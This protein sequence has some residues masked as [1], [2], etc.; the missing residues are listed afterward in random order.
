MISALPPSVESLRTPFKVVIAGYFNNIYAC[1]TA[2]RCHERG[3]AVTAFLF[4]GT[5][6]REL[7]ERVRQERTPGIVSPRLIDIVDCRIPSF[8]VKS[9]ND[10]AAISL[11]HD[12]S[13]DIVLQGMGPILKADFLAVPRIGILNSH[14]GL[15]PRYQGCSAVEWSIY[16]DDPVGST[17]H[18]L[19]EDVDAGPI[20]CSSTFDIYRG[21]TYQD[22]RT[23][24]FYHE[25][26]TLISGLESVIQGVR[27]AN[28]TPQVDGVYHPSAPHEILHAVR[29]KLRL[30]TY[31][32]LKDRPS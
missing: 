22:V 21:D 10:P 28:A 20:I 7:N 3:I 2:R 16:H 13:P 24:S 31:R 32:H 6:L 17:C 30:G 5:E 14:P 8:F 11:L 18:F 23:R 4:Q 12:L 1:E 25:I 19:T 27:L 15:L 9:L 29:E 26:D